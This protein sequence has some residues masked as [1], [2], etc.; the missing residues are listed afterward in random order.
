MGLSANP[1]QIAMWLPTP[2]Y[3]RVPHFWFLVGLMFFA[4]GLYIG[5]GFK[6]IFAY[7][8]LGALCI[9]RSVWIV[10]ARRRYRAARSPGI[11]AGP[12]AV[13]DEV[14]DADELQSTGALFL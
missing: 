1:R 4:F 2:V 8:V 9:A 3:E 5:F 11:E 12:G 6:L 10:H 13:R 7:L 14:S